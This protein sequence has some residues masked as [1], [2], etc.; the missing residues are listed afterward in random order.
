MMGLD[1]T[2]VRAVIY[3]ELRD[4]RRKRSIV[5]T[6][7]ILPAPLPRS[8]RHLHL[9]DHAE[10]IG[11]GNADRAFR[12]SFLLLLIPT[13]MPCTLAAYIGGRRA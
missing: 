8:A 6:M 13:I 2:R 9:L 4:F 12:S 5:V 10:L 11:S 3:K 1:A 7:C